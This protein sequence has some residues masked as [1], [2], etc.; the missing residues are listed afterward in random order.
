MSYVLNAPR[1]GVA[2]AQRS[3]AVIGV[4]EVKMGENALYSQDVIERP[5]I[6]EDAMVVTTSGV[7]I[8]S[9]SCWYRFCFL[10]I[11]FLFLSVSWF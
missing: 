4:D 10:F 1:N 6:F 7:L 8:W 5:L 2:A 9:S 3:R 11:L